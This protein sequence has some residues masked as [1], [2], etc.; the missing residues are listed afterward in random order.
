MTQEG[1]SSAT[2]NIP[3]VSWDS[4]TGT[5]QIRLMGVYGKD[6]EIDW[7]P[8]VTYV[9]RI[10]DANDGEWSVGF[11]TP[12][13]GV[14]FTNL[15]PDTEYELERRPK[16]N[17]ILG[18]PVRTRIRTEPSGDLPTGGLSHFMPWLDREG[19]E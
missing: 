1:W 9:V 10:R 6:L 18:E 2:Q 19:Q 13:T 4:N 8:E 16:K 15:T 12:I 17:G 7:K 11:E 5:F 3:P 14:A